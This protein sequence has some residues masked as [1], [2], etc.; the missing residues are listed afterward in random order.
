MTLFLLII[1][2]K[3]LRRIYEGDSRF[4]T[5]AGLLEFSRDILF[6]HSHYQVRRKQQLFPS[7]RQLR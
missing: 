3:F 5:G 4:G 1:C 6:I 7:Q 2:L